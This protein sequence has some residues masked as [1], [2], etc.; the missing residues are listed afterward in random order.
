MDDDGPVQWVRK[1]WQAT[2]SYCC[3]CCGFKTLR[4][5]GHFEICPV[6][7]WED[8]GQDESDK[9]RPLGGPNKLSLAAARENFKRLGAKEERVRKRVRP[10]TPDEM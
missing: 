2:K 1:P 6:C 10:P 9:D 5:R 4:G 7:G 8:D 3:P